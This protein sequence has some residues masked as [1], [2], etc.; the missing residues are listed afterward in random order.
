MAL[1]PE[2]KY[3]DGPGYLNLSDD[4]KVFAGYQT[5]GV[6]LFHD[7][8]DI[9]MSGLNTTVTFEN[10]VMLYKFTLDNDVEL[11]LYAW[12]DT[13]NLLYSA[14]WKAFY[15][16][17]E[18]TS[19]QY[20]Q[21]GLNTG[22]AGEV[23]DSDFIEK[24]SYYKTGTNL[25][26]PWK[27]VVQ[28]LYPA[29]PTENLTPADSFGFYLF[30]AS[31]RN[32]QIG[33]EWVDIRNDLDAIQPGVLLT[34]DNLVQIPYGDG[35]QRVDYNYAAWRFYN[36]NTT[37]AY[38][39]TA[40]KG[41]NKN[42]TGGSNQDPE[43]PE[44]DTS[45]TGGGGGVYDPT[46]DPVDFPSLPTGGALT[47]GMIKGFV[48]GQG[49]LIALQQK[50]WNMS[51]FDIE[52]QFQKLVQNPLE[53]LISLHC[54]PCLPTTGGNPENIKL[55]S[56]DTEVTGNR[57]TNQYLT[58]DAGTLNVPKYWGSALDY[59]PYTRAEI[60]LPFI[61]IRNLQIED[62][63]GLTLT[64]KYHVDV[65]TGDCVAYIK[66]GN[67]V[68][69]TFT[70]NCIQ[71]IPCTA[72][73]SDLLAKNISAVG[74]VG[75]GLATGNPAAAV[76]GAAAGAINSA[77]AKNHVQ[78]SGEVAGS[79]GVMSEFTPYMIFHRPKQSLAKNYN[80]FKGYPTNITYTLNTLTGYTEVEHVHLTGIKATD[81]EL[82]EI[83]NLLKSG[84]II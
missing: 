50:L 20:S 81:T 53:C 8:I 13:V 41:T 69:Y 63:Q 61:G 74:M 73:S 62:I 76:A 55:G 37:S 1:I 82:Q 47:S 38:M 18:F 79:P 24:G 68:L 5:G 27:L 23:N 58:V 22:M 14:V 45:G 72:T 66:C 51:I 15:D 75:V 52:T 40:G 26:V 64:L 17:V 48:I 80:K 65:L 78:R 12:F 71:H 19:Q 33:T 56:F 43:A 2:Y 54:L 16:G 83:E 31:H 70:G 6:F 29:N 35:T 30:G 36:L 42:I 44:D 11:R 25:D 67:S 28:T 3:P 77:T 32:V 4:D 9:D 21:S 57:I 59:A 10:P 84:V 60:F 49:N 7:I 34:F 46:S 39:K